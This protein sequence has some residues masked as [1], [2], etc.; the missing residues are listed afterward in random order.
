MRMVKP[1]TTL[2]LSIGPRRGTDA[3]IAAYFLRSHLDD[4]CDAGNVA[5][6]SG[7]GIV[8]S[9]LSSSRR[10][11]SHS[12]SVRFCSVLAAVYMGPRTSW[13]RSKLASESLPRKVIAGPSGEWVISVSG[14]DAMGASTLHDQLGCPIRKFRC[15]SA[16]PSASI[17]RDDAPQASQAEVEKPNPRRHASP[18]L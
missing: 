7:R 4:R 3:A 17:R 8:A 5:R 15:L 9:S 16:R 11:I 13:R 1:T 6:G 10:A 2:V 18:R 12:R 14:R